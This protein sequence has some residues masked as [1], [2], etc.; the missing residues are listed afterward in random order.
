LSYEAPDR[1][2][3]SILLDAE[4]VNQHLDALAGDEDLSRFIL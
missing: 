2:G 3:E 1:S 4:Y